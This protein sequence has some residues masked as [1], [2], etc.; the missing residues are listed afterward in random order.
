MLPECSKKFQILIIW[1]SLINMLDNLLYNQN[2]D[3]MVACNVNSNHDESLPGRISSFLSFLFSSPSLPPFFLSFALEVKTSL[4]FRWRK[5]TICCGPTDE[6]T[7]NPYPETNY[8]LHRRGSRKDAFSP[9]E[10]QRSFHSPP[11]GER[12]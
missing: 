8:E 2:V 12:A 7:K 3:L 6:C 11:N 1:P 10:Y 4:I 9:R 5:R